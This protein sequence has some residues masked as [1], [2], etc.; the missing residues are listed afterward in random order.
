[1]FNQPIASAG[2]YTPGREADASIGATWSALKLANGHLLIAPVLQ[3]IGSV[4]A[5]D[6]GPAAD[7]DNT[8]YRRLIAAPGV[9]FIT[10]KWRFYGDVEI[11][12]AQSFNGNQL[13][14]PAFFK[15]ILSRDF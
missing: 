12:F 14:A 3:V 2:G 6:S 15:V 9:Q 11:P 10:G 8:G 1:V 13:V 4:R 5:R 7:P